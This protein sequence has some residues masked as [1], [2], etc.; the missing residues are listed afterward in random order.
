MYLI[1]RDGFT[2]LAMGFAGE[3]ASA[4]IIWKYSRDTIRYS[5]PP[6]L[7]YSLELRKGADSAVLTSSPVA[8]EHPGYV[9]QDNKCYFSPRH[10]VKP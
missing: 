3:A 9:T 8:R 5:S 7:R 10:A 6:A 2:L 1:D 4:V